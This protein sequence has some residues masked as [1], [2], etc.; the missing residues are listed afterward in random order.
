MSARPSA[1]AVIVAGGSG[2]RMGASLPKQFLDLCGR[3]VLYYSVRAFLDALPGVRIILV[4][5]EQHMS[6]VQGVLEAFGHPVPLVTVPGGPTRYASVAAGLKEV[7]ADGIVLVHDGARPLVPAELIQRC[8]EGAG[9]NGSAVPVIP[10]ADSIRQM[11]GFDSR[12]VARE[13]LRIVQTPQAFRA[14]LLHQAFRQPYVPAFTDEASV[15]EWTGSRIHLV[16][17][18]RSNLKITTKE[19]LVIAEALLKAR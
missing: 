15:V 19:D 7:P 12:A 13:N 6:L 18:A 3:P 8:Y 5:P 10:V 14:S 11:S 16:E 17:G 9:M 2:S 1:Y 4:L